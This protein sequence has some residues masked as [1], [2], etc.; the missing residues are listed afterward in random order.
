LNSYFNLYNLQNKS[1]LFVDY[2]NTFFN[3]Y[4]NLYIINNMS[5]TN[6]S[7]NSIPTYVKVLGVI[8]V[9]WILIV[10]ATNVAPENEFIKKINFLVPSN[11]RGT[12][13]VT[14]TPVVTPTPAPV[15]TPTPAP[16][17]TPT[18]AP[19]VTPTPAPVV[20]PTPAPSG[21]GT[22]RSGKGKAQCP[23]WKSVF[24]NQSRDLQDLNPSSLSRGSP[25]I[26]TVGN[27][28]GLGNKITQYCVNS[29]DILGI[30]DPNYPD[31]NSCDNI[32]CGTAPSDKKLTYGKL[33]KS[34][35]CTLNNS[36]FRN[37]E[38][39]IASGAEGD[40]SSVFDSDGNLKFNIFA[41]SENGSNADFI[42]S[43]C[44]VGR[45]MLD[46]PNCN[47]QYQT[48]VSE[49]AAFKFF[50]CNDTNCCPDN[51]ASCTNKPK[52]STVCTK[53]AANCMLSK[54]EFVSNSYN[55][56]NFNP[57]ALNIDSEADKMMDYCSFGDDI[58]NENCKIDKYHPKSP[59]NQGVVL[60]PGNPIPVT[61]S[62][63]YNQYCSMNPA[64][65]KQIGKLN[66]YQWSHQNDA[67]S[68]LNNEPWDPLATISSCTGRPSDDNYLDT[69]SLTSNG[70]S[71]LNFCELSNSI[72]A[73]K[74]FDTYT[75]NPNDPN[76]SDHPP[77][78]YDPTYI[79][80]CCPNGLGDDKV[81]DIDPNIMRQLSNIV[82]AADKAH[83]T[84]RTV[85][86][87]LKG[88]NLKLQKQ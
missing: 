44:D 72:I 34:M 27:Y 40:V 24:S 45:R 12:N 68:I 47:K 48:Y 54:G 8:V 79:T 39:S 42:N 18:P 20:T 2:I 49:S 25:N 17:V 28:C 29:K 50:C 41:I 69:C 67:R 32:D 66:D 11:F 57:S 83:E 53:E 80:M 88:R 6:Q 87:Y 16:V 35:E 5:T 22:F 1:F 81:C 63:I 56:Q 76:A 73:N 75:V 3:K 78:P 86:Q 7:D 43:F 59:N 14:S 71:L 9:I 38:W 10:I 4:F 36:D 51:V 31:P 85:Y 21:A 13:K 64:C 37:F 55:Y 82:P 65:V 70:T 62:G 23:L 58:I 77:I 19:V 74:C 52:C 46:D 61:A 84:N 26:T 15:V 30:E 33:C 60:N